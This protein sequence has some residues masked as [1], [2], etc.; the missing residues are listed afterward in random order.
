MLCEIHSRD[1][2]EAVEGVLARHSLAF[3]WVT[4]DHIATRHCG[5]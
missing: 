5:D 3:E 2:R 4:G 1:E